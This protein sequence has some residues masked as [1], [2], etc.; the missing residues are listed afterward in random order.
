MILTE[1]TS[2]NASNSFCN[3][4]SV[5]LNDRLPTKMF[6]LVLF[7]FSAI[8]QTLLDLDGER[9]LTEIATIRHYWFDVD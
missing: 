6:M 2:P 4:S 5:V 1:P 8:R 7:K 3:S 9:M